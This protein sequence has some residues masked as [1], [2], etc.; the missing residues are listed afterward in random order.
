MSLDMHTNEVSGGVSVGRREMPA[1]GPVAVVSRLARGTIEP[2]Y[3]RLGFELPFA[4]FVTLESEM[5][6]Q[7]MIPHLLWLASVF[8]T[9]GLGFQDAILLET[10]SC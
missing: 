9:F 1:V 4:C 3:I 10:C 6:P 8:A 5:R 2:A 7:D